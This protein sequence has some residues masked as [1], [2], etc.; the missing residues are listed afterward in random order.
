MPSE[1][2]D[3]PWWELEHFLARLILN[4]GMDGKRF[5][6]AVIGV[7]GDLQQLP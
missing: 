2:R 7:T 5:R 6:D 1:R 4:T 3:D